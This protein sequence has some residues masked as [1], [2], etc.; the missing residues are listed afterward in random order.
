M[1]NTNVLLPTLLALFTIVD[2]FKHSDYAGLVA[3][4]HYLD[5]EAIAADELFK[6]AHIN[7]DNFL[8]DDEFE[9]LRAYISKCNRVKHEIHELSLRE[10]WEHREVDFIPH[11]SAIGSR[12]SNKEIEK[13]IKRAEA[14][15]K[16]ANSPTYIIASMEENIRLNEQP[17][18]SELEE[19]FPF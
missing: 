15:D 13:M 14:A 17:D 19:L 11:Y 10:Y 18:F 9:E 6:D 8:F 12:Y 2:S 7:W 16:R 4:Y 1:S 5:E 3:M